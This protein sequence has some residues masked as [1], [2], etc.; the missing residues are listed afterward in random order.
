MNA[1]KKRAKK[2]SSLFQ[3]IK[4]KIS[5]LL[6]LCIAG[7]VTA[8]LFLILPNVKSSMKNLTQ[9]YLYD[10][11]VSAGERVDLVVLESSLEKTMDPQSLNQLVGSIGLEGIDSSYAYVVSSDG[12]MLYHPTESKI[13]QPVENAVVSGLVSEIQSGAKNIK[14]QVVDYEF[15]GVTKYAA[16]YVNENSDYI[17]V[18]SADEDEVM[19]PITSV[20]NKLA[21][22]DFTENGLST[23]QE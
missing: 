16:Y 6:F 21:E 19:Q 7:V 5:L 1:P 11:T 14:P 20:I 4:G 22:M 18:I 8:L 3:S 23:R 9:N 12:T 2:R 13:G 17:I 15:K 10:I